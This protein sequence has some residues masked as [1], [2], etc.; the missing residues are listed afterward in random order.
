[1]A[2]QP[3][4]VSMSKEAK[5]RSSARLHTM[6]TPD[7]RYEAT[8]IAF[9]M[10]RDADTLDELLKVRTFIQQSGVNNLILIRTLKNKMERFR[11]PHYHGKPT[12]APLVSSTLEHNKKRVPVM[13]LW[14]RTLA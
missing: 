6:R 9:A 10:M 12:P 13:D 8:R 1:M 5:R 2:V 11:M 14:R 7:K 3:K 4:E